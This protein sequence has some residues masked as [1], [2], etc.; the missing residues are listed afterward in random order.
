MSDTVELPRWMVAAGGALLL[1]TVA[2]SA[3][4]LG[5]TSVGPP[6]PSTTEQAPVPAPSPPAAAS[7]LPAE[8]KASDTGQPAVADAPP[9]STPAASPPSV[10]APAPEGPKQ[11]SEPNL[12]ADVAQY[13]RALDRIGGLNPTSID[14]NTI[15]Q[16]AL[17]G[18]VSGID[19]LIAEHR[20]RQQKIRQLRPP[21]PCSAYHDALTRL[22]AD[23]LVV[24]EQLRAGILNNNVQALMSLQ[25][26]AMRL[27]ALGDEVSRMEGELRNRYRVH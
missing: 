17:G 11:S 4:L 5:R 1:C 10:E 7:V 24:M 3:F 13:F 27:Q 12:S 19:S 2:T 26:K 25:G 20:T 6:A 15:I 9:S 23:G 8:P 22:A 21:S 16:Q 14:P 18:D